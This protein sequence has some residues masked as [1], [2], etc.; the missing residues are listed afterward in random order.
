[1]ADE[2]AR[3]F[4]LSLARRLL[5]LDQAGLQAW[6]EAELPSLKATTRRGAAAL[7]EVLRRNLP[8]AEFAALPSAEGFEQHWDDLAGALSGAADPAELA[9]ARAALAEKAAFGEERVEL[10]LAVGPAAV[11][12]RPRPPGALSDRDLF[13][14]DGPL[15]YL[16]LTPAEVE[17]L[18]R[19]LEA[20]QGGHAGGRLAAA[21]RLRALGER[22]GREP[23]LRVAW[24]LAR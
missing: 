23:G 13:E 15:R 11:L 5:A 3:L 16:L 1:M 12:G 18:A 22:C 24:L 20:A 14:G 21:A 7:L 9:L 8:P 6:L 10:D 4:D 17:R 19:A 2:A